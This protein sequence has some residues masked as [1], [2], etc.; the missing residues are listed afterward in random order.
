MAEVYRGYVGGK[1]PILDMDNLWGMYLDYETQMKVTD[2]VKDDV[3]RAV[4]EKFGVVV[5]AYQFYPSNYI[6]AKKPIRTAADIKG[7][8]IRSPSLIV[9]DLLEAMGAQVQ[10]SKFHDVYKSLQGETLDAAV[11]CGACGAK[12]LWHEVSDY[13]VGPIVALPHTW[14][15][16]DAAQ[17]AELSP[18]LQAII[19]GEAKRHEELTKK[20]SLSIWDGVME[21]EEAGM[22]HIEFTPELKELARKAALNK[23]LP[24][25][26]RRTGGPDSDPARIYNIKVAPILGV[27]ITAEGKARELK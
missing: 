18:D 24:N 12:M 26:V 4:E 6:F 20:N 14:I 17:W 21:N 22:E 27:E 7:L 15:T 23:V 9:T 5:L 16:M 10:G 13:L 3:D 11:S 8:R 2:A 25:W 19:L 1:L